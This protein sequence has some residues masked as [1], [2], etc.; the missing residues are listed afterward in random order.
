[1]RYIISDIHGCYEEYREL[2][3]KIHFSENDLLYVLGDAMDRGPEPIRVIQDMIA[4]K[5]VIYIVGNHDYMM[6]RTLKKLAVEITE[7]NC[8]THLTSEDL[9]NCFYWIQDGGRTTSDQFRAL[10][11]REQQNILDYVGDAYIYEVL[12]E[13]WCWFMPGSAVL[14]KKKAWMNMTC[15]ILSTNAQTITGDIIRILIRSW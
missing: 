11:R 8:E 14:K 13:N 3:E 7:E 9:I 1:M 5:N 6:L 4:R 12:K 15:L 10:S 2:L